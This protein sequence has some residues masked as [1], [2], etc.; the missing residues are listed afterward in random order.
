[1]QSLRAFLRALLKHRII[2]TVHTFEKRLSLLTPS[3]RLIA[4][5]LALVMTFSVGALL[6]SISISLTEVVPAHGGT[7]TEGLI[8]SPRFINPVLAIS[9]TDRDLTT[10]V[11]SGLLQSN[12]DGSLSPDLAESYTVSDDKRTYTF[13]LK[14]TARFHDGKQV[15][16]DDVLFT[17]RAVENPDIKSPR[18]AD[19]E[20]VEVNV[21]DTKTVSFV[22]KT[23][24]APFLENMTVG[25]VPKHI[26]QDV[27]AE[28]F[29]FSTR[30]TEPVGSGPYRVESVKRNSSGISTEYL[31]TA[32]TSGT[33]IPYIDHIVFKIYS[34]AENLKDALNQGKVQAA[35]SIEPSGTLAPIALNE[36]V[37][38]RV[39]GV[40]FNQ[41]QNKIFADTVVRRALDKAVDKQRIVSTV[42]G[43]HGS[44]IDGPLPPDSANTAPVETSAEERILKAREIL[45]NGGW[46]AGADG[47][48]TKT[49]VVAKKKETVRL[50]FSLSTSNVPELKQSAEMVADD[51]RQIGAD[52]EL[53][54]F[55]QN[56]LNVGV[57]RPRKY[58]ALLFGLVIGRDLDLFAFWH[59][60]QRND[61]GLN[62]ALYANVDNDKKLEALRTI[63]DPVTRLER[64]RTVAESI[65]ND[66]AAVFLYTPYFVYAT[67]PELSGM[68][69]GTIATPSDRFIRADQ[70][71]LKTERVWPIF[72]RNIL[73]SIFH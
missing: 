3:D 38:G 2:P 41:S 8:G 67:P 33:R 66:I 31:L 59:S 70:W 65:Q 71:F 9:D 69:L 72:K 27:T 5:T 18:R 61:P 25:I 32:I 15:T 13:V 56:D 58:D 49:I 47:I 52:V 16:A 43:G 64:A 57:L 73:E 14:D 26:W 11:F 36:A 60:S 24:Y 50:A 10:L 7:Y 44:V 51:W 19:W 35:H 20:G 62:I 45:A 46:K 28:E 30:N 23:P 37:F 17:I 22:L 12:P 53:K 48:L 29:P 4:G 6:A 1:M 21:I 34:N 39:F 55:D 40:F 68:H 42:L 63:S 54:F